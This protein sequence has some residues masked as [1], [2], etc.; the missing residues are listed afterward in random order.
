MS[1]NL[2]LLIVKNNYGLKNNNLK[3]NGTVIVNFKN[4]LNLKHQ[5]E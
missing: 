5:G 2:N 3:I 4:Y 1:Q